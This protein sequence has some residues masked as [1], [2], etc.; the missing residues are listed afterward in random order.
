M[1]IL[2][3]FDTIFCHLKQPYVPIHSPF[4]SIYD[5][6]KD[7]P[8][9]VHDTRCTIP[10]RSVTCG[11]GSCS[12][13]GCSGKCENPVFRSERYR[14]PPGLRGSLYCRTGYIG[15]P[16]WRGRYFGLLFWRGYSAPPRR[17]SLNKEPLIRSR[18]SIYDF[19]FI[20]YNVILFQR[21]ITRCHYI[22]PLANSTCNIINSRLC[23]SES[24]FI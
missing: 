3:A 10:Q 19:L 17:L 4:N 14:H 18:L 20:H 13:S 22:N 11:F 8:Y 23:K 9:W 21:H 15:F 2:T 12:F 16:V 24:I 7:N 1:N 6:S 5:H